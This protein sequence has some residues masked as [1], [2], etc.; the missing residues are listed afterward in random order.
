MKD[1]L[2]G[3]RVGELFLAEVVG[4][5]LGPLGRLHV[6]EL[7]HPAHFSCAVGDRYAIERDGSLEA[8]VTIESKGII[9]QRHDGSR[10]RIEDGLT[11]KTGLDELVGWLA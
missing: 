10:I 9:V 4:R 5:G 2:D 11:V 3:P 6:E 1:D 8:T 7:D